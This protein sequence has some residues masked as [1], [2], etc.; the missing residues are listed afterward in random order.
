MKVILLS[1]KARH[2]KDTVA[3]MIKKICKN[4][5]VLIL[6]YAYYI[7]EFA[8]KISDWDGNDLNKPRDLLQ[9]LG[10]DIIK[11]KIDNLFFVKR[12]I[13]DLKVYAY[14]FDIVIIPDARYE[15]EITNIKDVYKDS[16]S[17]NVLRTN[18]DNDLTETQ[19][20]HLT[21]TALDNF[22]NYDYNIL[23]DSDLTSLEKKVKEVVEEIGYE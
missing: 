16:Y 12:M 19:K 21:E 7:K 13:E 6:P 4:K 2:G 8:K 11:N 10:T 22:S 3:L 14:Y 20:K 9:Q 23:N 18:F 1:G 17:I 5:Q 15:E